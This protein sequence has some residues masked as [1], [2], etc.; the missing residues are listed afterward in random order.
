LKLFRNNEERAGLLLILPAFII[1]IGLIAYPF[2]YSI[3]LSFTDTTFG[4]LGD[5]VG[6]KNFINLAKSSRFHDVLIRTGIYTVGSLIPKFL[7]GLGVALLIRSLG[8]K[9]WTRFI[10]GLFLFPWV[11]P[12]SLSALAWLWLYSPNFSVLNWIIEKI[13]P[14]S[15]GIG[16]VLSPGMALFS[17]IL[18]NIWRGVPFFAISF[19]AGLLSIDEE[20]YEA[21]DV[22]GANGLQKLLY[23]SLPLLKPVVSVVLLFSMLMTVAEF[24]SIYVITNGGPQSS[25]TI[26]A[27]YSYVEG[28]RGGSLGRGAAVSLFIF[29]ILFIVSY[30]QL[31]TIRKGIGRK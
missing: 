30:F 25:T 3:I 14:G 29:P 18:F 24:N 21:A 7:F 17:V 5:F 6:F 1:I 4:V 31:R 13:I 26:L 12:T 15:G 10:K 27:F 28:I 23:I 22:E 16:W 9:K 11:V 8:N 2:F 20:L 19:L